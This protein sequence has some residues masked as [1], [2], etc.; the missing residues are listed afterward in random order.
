[1][2]KAGIFRAERVSGV[3]GTK[4]PSKKARH[5]LELN[6]NTILIGFP[7]HP[8]PCLEELI[9]SGLLAEEFITPK[10]SQTLGWIGAF[11]RAL[12]AWW[13]CHVWMC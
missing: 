6:P 2:S 1:M 4:L 10:Q 3:D 8:C 9:D 13:P 12:G 7:P 5:D 11:W